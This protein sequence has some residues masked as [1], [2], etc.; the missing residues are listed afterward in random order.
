M[1]ST[2]REDAYMW[3]WALLGDTLSVVAAPPTLDNLVVTM[4]PRSHS[5]ATWSILNG[6]RGEVEVR[7]CTLAAQ[8]GSAA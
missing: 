3:R 5:L 6:A 7:G 4:R 1:P 2:G 8:P